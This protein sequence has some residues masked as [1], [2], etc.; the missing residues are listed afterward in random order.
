MENHNNMICI[1][2]VL[3]ILD[4]YLQISRTLWSVISFSDVNV[5]FKSYI[6]MLLLQNLHKYAIINNLRDLQNNLI[7]R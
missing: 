2:S 7:I 5:V 3:P 1:L 4:Y 6:E